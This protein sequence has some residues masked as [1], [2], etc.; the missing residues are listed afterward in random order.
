MESI[1]KLT[2]TQRLTV[3][4]VKEYAENCYYG[5]YKTSNGKYVL[6]T[7]TNEYFYKNLKDVVDSINN[8]FQLKN[9]TEED[10]SDDLWYEQ[11][12][13][14]NFKSVCDLNGF[15]TVQSLPVL[16]EDIETHPVLVLAVG[17][18][19]IDQ[20]V[21]TFKPVMNYIM[22]KMLKKINCFSDMVINQFRSVKAHGFAKN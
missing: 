7:D 11:Q 22:P 18:A 3:N 9:E 15:C 19:V 14:S 16:P 2:R 6:S 12:N 17:S 20:I 4:Q 8:G 13:D 10:E 5:F 1:T 21:T